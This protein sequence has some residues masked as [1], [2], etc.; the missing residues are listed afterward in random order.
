VSGKRNEKGGRE[1]YVA[2]GGVKR[3]IAISVASIVES[4]IHV[5]PYSLT[6]L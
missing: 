6:V 3:A 1:A 4:A 5:S 2:V